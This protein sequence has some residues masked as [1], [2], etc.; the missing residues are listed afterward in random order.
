ML[1]LL[2][3]ILLFTWIASCLLFAWAVLFVWGGIA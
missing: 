2:V 1:A 3:D